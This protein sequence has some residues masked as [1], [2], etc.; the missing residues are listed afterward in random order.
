MRFH[1]ALLALLISGCASI[2]LST[3]AR[4]ST[5]DAQKIAEIDPSQVRVRIAVPVGYDV[6]P[7]HTQ[8]TFSL[9]SKAGVTVQR[10]LELR[11][12]A[13]TKGERSPGWL[14]QDIAVNSYDLALS[15]QGVQNMLQLQRFSMSE[16]MESFKININTKF[17]SI[18]PT[19]QTMRIWADIKLALSDSFV[20]LID[21]GEIRFEQKSG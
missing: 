1:A 13:V 8:L 19:A 2:P 21:G 15:P 12:L 4:F 3:M 17:A 10:A 14:G 5:L 16:K 11:G 6:D 7:A 9:T 18:P 20:R